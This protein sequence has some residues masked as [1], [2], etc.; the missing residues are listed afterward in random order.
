M[1]IEPI[2]IRLAHYL[3]TVGWKAIQEFFNF[4]YDRKIELI[5]SPYYDHL[6]NFT[7]DIDKF[8]RDIKANDIITNIQKYSAAFIQFIRERYFAFV[9]F[10]KEL[11]DV[12]EEIVRELKEL[13]KLPSVKYAAEKLEQAYERATYLWQYFEVRAKLESGFRLLHTKLMDISQTA[14]QAE[15]R[16]RE[17][18]TKFIYDPNN[19]LM[20]LEQK[21]PMSWHAFNQTPEFQE[22]PEY[23]AIRDMGSYFTASNTTFWT[24]YYQFKP[25]TEPSNWLPPFKGK[26]LRLPAAL[27]HASTFLTLRS[28]AS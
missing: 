12:L 21:L 26:Q 25:L 27:V 8:Y 18:K 14:L 28:T 11:K 19:G 10:G 2:F 23:K 3:E 1:H 16:Y 20:C 22:I 13:R 4:L 6:S 24:L 9:P 7:Q 17:A 15:S 5:S